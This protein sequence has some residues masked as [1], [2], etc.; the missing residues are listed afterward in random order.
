MQVEFEVTFEPAFGLDDSE[1]GMLKGGATVR[2][3]SELREDWRLDFQTMSSLLV[4]SHIVDP[5]LWTV[6]CVK[7]ELIF[8]VQDGL[9][10]SRQHA[11]DDG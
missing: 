6:T 5:Y 3:G 9:R 2:V 1:H 4:P 10:Q 7:L 8:L 11:R